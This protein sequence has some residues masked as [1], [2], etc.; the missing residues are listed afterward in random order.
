[1]AAAF[2][3][4]MVLSTLTDDKNKGLVFESH[5]SKKINITLYLSIK[6]KFFCM[7]C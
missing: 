7:Y 2:A 5:D 4:K 1:M 3:G 6:N